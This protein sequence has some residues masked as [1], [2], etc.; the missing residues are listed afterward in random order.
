[1]DFGLVLYE[2]F[3]CKL[4]LELFVSSDRD[5]LWGVFFYGIGGIIVELFYVL[6]FLFF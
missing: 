4:W 3:F 1:M 2:D 6:D 5:G